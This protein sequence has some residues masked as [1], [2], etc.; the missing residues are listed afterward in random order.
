VRR[1]E[2]LTYDEPPPWLPP[3]RHWLGGLLLAAERAAA[4]EKVYREDLEIYP[5]NGWSLAGL[6]RSLEAQGKDAEAERAELA[7]AT[8]RADVEITASRR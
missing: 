6:A 5:A 4:A 2:G 7:E 3:A 8:A 1:E